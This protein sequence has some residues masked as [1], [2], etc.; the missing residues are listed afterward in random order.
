MNSYLTAIK[1]NND[2]ERDVTNWTRHRL[3]MVMMVRMSDPN[4]IPNQVM[5]K[6]QTQEIMENKRPT[7]WCLDTTED[8]DAR[9]GSRSST[10]RLAMD[11]QIIQIIKNFYFGYKKND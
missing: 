4:W 5:Q 8:L 10:R 2:G 1:D 9:E 7:K 3:Q 6:G 11:G